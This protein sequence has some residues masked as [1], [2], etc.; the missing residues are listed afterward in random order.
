MSTFR[1]HN[2]NEMSV[3]ILA[4]C[5]CILVFA[6]VIS[7]PNSPEGYAQPIQN[8]STLSVSGIASMKIKPD[9]FTVSFGVETANTTASSAL[10]SNSEIMNKI[11]YVLKTAG[12]QQ[13]E[14]STSSFT[15]NPNYNYSE[16]GTIGNITGYT[17]T[18]S[19]QISSSNINNISTWIDLAVSTGANRVDSIYF[20][21]SDKKLDDIK[22]N[23]LKDAV[24]NAKS[25][26]DIAASVLG[27][28]VIGV[29]SINLNGFELPP[30][31]PQPYLSQKSMTAGAETNT[32]STPIITGEQEI[33]TQVT[34]VF[35][36]GM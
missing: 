32:R 35:L 31:V 21:V 24:N 17:A 8:N 2:L 33:T 10:M 15:I 22:N 18:N 25:K 14:T 5:I 13:N 36:L 19:I 16:S 12:V 29:R 3:L 34:I 27:L 4:A 30:P 23:L 26:A 7:V 6:V 9:R 1:N 11:L 20:T 28:K